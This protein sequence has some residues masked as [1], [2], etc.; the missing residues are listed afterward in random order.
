MLIPALVQLEINEFCQ[1]FMKKNLHELW[2]HHCS[3]KQDPKVS[4]GCAILIELEMLRNAK[5][6]SVF[7]DIF[8]FEQ[9]DYKKARNTKE[10]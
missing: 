2:L 6:L 1:S 10:L 5:E 9:M 7:N 3:I 4:K 8:L